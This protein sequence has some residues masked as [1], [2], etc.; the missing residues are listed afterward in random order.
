MWTDPLGDCLTGSAPAEHAPTRHPAA[1][2]GRGP[3]TETCIL[4]SPTDMHV[5]S[6]TDH[7]SPQLGTTQMP[8]HRGWTDTPRLSSRWETTQLCGCRSHGNMND[9]PQTEQ[10]Q[11][12]LKSA[13]A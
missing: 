6:S 9:S 1:L 12:T 4:G 2:L 7:K 5:T 11:W 13:H 8:I 10:K 3:R